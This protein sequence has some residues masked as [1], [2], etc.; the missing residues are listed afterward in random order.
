[1]IQHFQ[2]SS[3]YLLYPLI[4]HYKYYVE[5]Q[6]TLWQSKNIQLLHYSQCCLLLFSGVLILFFIAI[7]TL[8]LNLILG[9]DSIILKLVLNL[10]FLIYFE[11]NHEK[12][13]MEY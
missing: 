2:Q 12:R 4:I 1:M 6:D 9:F 13:M 11:L 3:F 8:I 5:I 7:I 10:E